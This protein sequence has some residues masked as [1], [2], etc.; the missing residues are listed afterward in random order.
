MEMEERKNR[1][2]RPYRRSIFWPL[3]LITAGVLWM[4]TSLNMLNGD[5]WSI[6]LRFWP[7]LF[8]VSGIDS[9]YRRSHFVGPMVMIAIGAVLLLNNLGYLRLSWQLFFSLWPVLLIAAGLD[10]IIGRRSA[11]SAVVGIALG[12]LLIA[13]MVWLVV[14]AP[15]IGQVNQFEALS[16]PL[17]GAEKATVELGNT[18]GALQLSSGAVSGNLLNASLRHFSN[19]SIAAQDY[20][21][22]NGR[23]YYGIKTQ[24]FYMYPAPAV[25]SGRADWEVKMASNVPLQLDSNLV[26]GEQRLD[27]SEL[28]VDDLTAETVMGRVEVTLPQEGFKH[29]RIHLVMGQVVIYVPRG[30]NVHITTNTVLVPISLPAGFERNGKEIT[31][32]NPG[33]GPA[34][35]L[36]VSDVMGVVSIEYR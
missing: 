12:A 17:N 11:W 14:S 8:I 1:H 6:V 18:V 21:V 16:Q 32:L 27:L 35:Q 33:S 9:I 2:N 15:W 20:V 3:F 7:L 36:D 19:E 29:G 13:S 23:G 25:T 30:A 4:L 34:M 10:I 22:Q 5:I 24:G 31:S 28:K 26:M